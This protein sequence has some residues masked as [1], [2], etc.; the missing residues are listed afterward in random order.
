MNEESQAASSGLFAVFLLSIYSLLLIPYTIYVLCASEDVTTQPVVKVRGRRAR[1]KQA[2]ARC[3]PRQR[4]GVV[5]VR[6]GRR[7]LHWRRPLL[8]QCCA[9]YVHRAPGEEGCTLEA[10]PAGSVHS[11]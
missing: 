3:T 5:C 9:T 4:P 8:A 11:T 6:S 7:C 2:H 10:A 1:H